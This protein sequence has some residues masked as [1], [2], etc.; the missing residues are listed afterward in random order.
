MPIDL[1][2]STNAEEDTSMSEITESVTMIDDQ[3]IGFC[4]YG[5]GEHYML[6]ICGAVGENSVVLFL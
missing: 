5:L 1:A 6:F 3:K 2:D 4:R